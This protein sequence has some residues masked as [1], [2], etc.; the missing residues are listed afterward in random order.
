VPAFQRTLKQHLVSYTGPSNLVVRLLQVKT[1]KNLLLGHNQ[2]T[3]L[4][5]QLGVHQV[6][7]SCFVI[8]NSDDNN[9]ADQFI[10]LSA[11]WPL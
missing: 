10:G 11:Y 2:L 8:D 3:A 7:T 4:P 1:L 5:D 9:E 6:L